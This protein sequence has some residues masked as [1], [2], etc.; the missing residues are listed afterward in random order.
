MKPRRHRSASLGMAG[1]GLLLTTCNTQGTRP[2][3][4]EPFFIAS[5]CWQEGGGGNGRTTLRVGQTLTLTLPPGFG[6]VPL[7][8]GTG[9]TER[10]PVADATWASSN[11]GVAGV[12]G[13]TSGGMSTAAV[14]ALAPGTTQI[15][16][17]VKWSAGTTGTTAAGFS[18]ISVGGGG[19]PKTCTVTV[20]N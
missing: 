3:G 5:P 4:N 17:N 12:E 19:E 20:T 6:V 11:P 9:S 7:G 2:C 15:S 1:L 14:R 8:G 10:C 13:T 18:I 16:A